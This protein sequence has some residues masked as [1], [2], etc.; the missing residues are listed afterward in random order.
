MNTGTDQIIEGVTFQPWI[1]CHYKIG[2]P[3]LLVVGQSHYD[4]ESR[5]RE[6]ITKAQV[7]RRVIKRVIEHGGDRAFFTNVAA[8]CLD[9]L[10]DAG[11]RQ[12]FWNSVSFYNYIQEFVG[13][14]PRQPHDYPLWERSHAAFIRVLRALR[15]QLILVLGS[16]NFGSMTDWKCRTA[17]PLKSG[18]ALYQ[19]TWMY[20]IGSNAPALAFHV[21][22]PSTGYDFRKFAPLFAE[23]RQRVATRLRHR[24]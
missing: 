3:R 18:G 2:T 11:A 22:H 1:G 17:A 8:T 16:A 12:Q 13:N 9:E 10:P 19:E 7:T 14:T 6:H 20:S 24:T 4:W 21:K 23:A 5:R 15:P